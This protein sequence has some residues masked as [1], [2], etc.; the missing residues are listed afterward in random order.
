LLKDP[1]VLL[2][3]VFSAVVG[4]ATNVIA[5]KMMFAPLEFIG[6]RPFLGWQGIIPANAKSLARKSTEII[7]EK[8]INL[9]DLFENFDPAQFAGENLNHALDELTDEIIGEIGGTHA[10]PG[11]WETMPEPVKQQVRGMLRAEIQQVAT[12]ILEEFGDNI[13]DILDLKRAVLEAVDRDRKII[14]D[15]FEQTGAE[16]FSFIKRS[17]AYFGLMF[18]LFQLG[19]WIAYPRWW[20]LPFFGFFVGYATNW[21]ALKLIFEPAEPV[22]VGPFTFHGLFHKRQH[23]VAESFAKLVSTDV[24]NAENLVLVM[25]TGEAGD[26]LYGIV[27][28]HIGAMLDK[29]SKNPMTAAMVPADKWPEIRAEIFGRLR[30]DMPKPGG[31]LH[32]FTARAIDVYGELFDRMTALDS[33]SFEGILRPA[34]QK[35]EWKLIIAGAA[36][37]FGAGVLQVLYVFGDMLTA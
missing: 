36:L 6:V 21:L 20:I 17:G 16:E 15:M 30:Q 33:R 1:I 29:Y 25:T 37:G 35:D 10:A 11:T 28:K 4:W 27:E 12:D 8:L 22:K 26:R 5:V 7:T 32:V 2:I 3:P 14:G 19:A 34:F 18:G 31:F 9:R 24:L 23:E 13:E